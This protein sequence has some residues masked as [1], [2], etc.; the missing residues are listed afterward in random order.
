MDSLSDKAG[1]L[2]V[3]NLIKYAIGF[4]VPVAMVRLLNQHDYGTYQQV[5]LIG[6]AVIGVMVLGIP[7]SIYYFHHHTERGEQPVLALQTGVLLAGAGLIAGLVVALMSPWLAVR[8]NNPALQSLLHI[9]A[10]YIGLFIAC[11]YFMHWLVSENRYRAALGWESADTFMRAT[12]LL[13]PLWLG[14]ELT[15]VVIAAAV[16]AAV[17]FSARTGFIWRTVRGA[18]TGWTRHT[19]ARSQL[20]YSIPLGLTSCVGLINGLADR[21]LVA[22]YFSPAQFAIYAVGALEIPL[23]VI[24]QTSVANVLR[25]TFPRLIREG[26]MT[27][28][29]QVWRETVRKLALVVLPSFAFLLTFSHE[30]VVLLFTGDYAGSAGVFRIYLFLMPLQILVLSVIPQAFG[31]TR[32]NLYL[33]LISMIINLVLC[34]ALIDIIGFYGAALSTVSVAYLMSGIYLRVAARL[35][36][37]RAMELLPLAALTRIGLSAAAAAVCAQLFRP[38]SSIPSVDFIVPG[39]VFAIAYFAIAALLGAFTVGDRRLARRWILKLIPAYS[40]PRTL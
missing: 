9:Y 15:G 13:L 10:L 5:L 8:M 40:G 31:R 16:Y 20:R 29:V 25:A 39:M 30:F 35:I 2:I 24:F 23:D 12:V 34:V 1:F 27:E 3:A 4:L 28:L 26:N 7:T 6:N 33:A 38:A 32:I 36:G 14:F 17:R 19:F 37:V 11:E 18:V 21:V 22:A